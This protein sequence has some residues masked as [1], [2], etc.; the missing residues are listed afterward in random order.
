MIFTAIVCAFP[1][2]ASAAYTGTNS[3]HSSMIPAGSFEANLTDEEIEV[4]LNGPKNNSDSSIDP[5][6]SLINY[7]FETA[8]EMLGFELSKG[9]L[10]CITKGEYTL[11]INK[12]SG[13]VYFV[14]NITG[15]ILT[16]NPSDP[17]Y[18]DA[19]GSTAVEH[20][21][22]M[23]LMSQ[24]VV[25]F[26]ETA[27]SKNTFSFS[28][29]EQAALRGQI[30]VSPINGGFRVNYTLG[31][32]TARYLLPGYITE[33]SFVENIFTPMLDKY[34]GLL[35]LYCAD[36]ATEE[37]YELFDFFGCDEYQPYYNGHFT[38][39]KVRKG[40]FYYLDV[41]YG[42]YEGK[43]KENS[44][45]YAALEEVRKDF[46]NLFGFYSLKAPDT[47]AS[48][49]SR[50][51]IYDAYPIT[52][53]ANG[54]YSIFVF[55]SGFTEA[56]E[57]QINNAKNKASS[58]IKANCPS[59]TYEMMYE[60]EAE[61]MYVDNSPVKPYVRCALEY[62]LNDDGSISVRLPANSIKFD[63]TKYTFDSITPLKYFGAPNMRTDSYIF[64]PDGSGAIV[65]LSDF[66]NEAA[67]KYINLNMS[68]DVYGT[69]YCYSKIDGAFRENVSMP[70]FGAV[71]EVNANAMTAA[72]SGSATVNNGF[73]AII[74]EGSALATIGY[75]SDART[76]KYASV[77]TGYTPYPSDV[78]DLNETISTG[79]LGV[80]TMVSESKYTGSYVTRYAMLTDKAVGEAKYGT[81]KYY[82]ADYVGMAAYYRSYLEATGAMQTLEDVSTDLPLY[83]E[84]FGAMDVLDRFLTIPITKSIALTTFDDIQEIYSQLSNSVAYVDEL[85]AKYETLVAEETDETQKL[86]YQKQLD[87]Y[88]ALK[89]QITDI[90]NINFKLTG[91]AN[92]GM[93]STYP[94]KVKWQ[95]SCGGSSGF[96]NLVA[97]ANEVTA[98]GNGTFGIYPEFDFMYLGKTALFDG[99]SSRGNLS[100]MVD[101]R[102]ASKQVYDNV[103]NEFEKLL[104]L[105][106][107]PDAID[108]YYT[109]FL[110]SYSKY[111]VT[112][113]SVSTMGSDI[114][115]NFD[116]KNPINRE[117]AR[118]YVMQVLDRMTDEEN[119]NSY[120][121]M[122]DSGNIY[123]V[124]YASHILNVS[125]DSS[126]LRYASY[127]V[128][129]VG[130]VLHSYVN[131]T[132]TPINYSGNPDYDLLRS[133]E[134]GASLYYI[135][136]YQNTAKMKESE[137]LSQYYGVDYQN[138]FDSIL[139]TYNELNSLIG[140]LQDYKIYDHEFLI[141]ERAIDDDE[142]AA[143]YVT[144]KAELLEMLEAQIEAAVDAKLSEL[145]TGGAAN[146]DKRIKLTVD[147]DALLVQFSEILNTSVDELYTG[148]FKTQLDKIISDSEAEYAGAAL[149]ANDV[150]VSF[151]EVN[152]VSKYAYITDS[153][154]T[155]ED[156]VYTKYTL[157]NG[158][159]SVVTYKKGDHE[160]KFILNYNLF[161][162]TVRLD[163]EHEYTIQP[164]KYEMLR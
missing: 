53:P 81:D 57:A 23:E 71:T 47:L 93:D 106:I 116:K 117:E 115:S 108:K 147:K 120:D 126:H 31:D 63:D 153:F 2:A 24:I 138:W 1:M 52:D 65:D 39:S 87:R 105:V 69:D 113:I 40:L 141:A 102:Y 30:S 149:S 98:S 9:Y 73:V 66:Y 26:H 140:D 139:T 33:E 76:Y 21:A 18:T 160:V 14:N 49:E 12:Y 77:Y 128:P 125:T 135:V 151:S 11:F 15:Q 5:S 7:N 32:T 61:C 82:K 22:R 133:I 29:F 37:D 161:P 119:E 123:T 109:K 74:E 154:A 88:T 84:V 68:A 103:D 20:D 58:I 17:A 67:N 10:Y 51:A 158:N 163:A 75:D 148:D 34:V 25:T 72:I 92:G 90:K 38:T 121:V 13:V 137:T 99:F 42:V 101:N 54:G 111:D 164:N 155:D 110:K 96:A 80:Y 157:D 127:T 16:S 41:T 152:Y 129:F 143:N 97:K 27:N 104:T 43:I 144:L 56:D 91:F 70:V 130:L 162:V 6:E 118:E 85:I 112:G 60:D 19:S 107:S 94:A 28:S 114:N 145:A 131:Y 79:G 44:P 8:A 36:F 122:L 86:Q 159:V 136:C 46:I 142:I 146:Y 64:Y 83:L 134:N 55:E 78:Y 124:E 100:R 62:I 35:E 48:E 3:A 59:Y 150:A 95:R 50:Q 4:Y 89:G 45:E 156:Y 132:G